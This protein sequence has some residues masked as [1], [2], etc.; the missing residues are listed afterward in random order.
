MNLLTEHF[1]LEELTDSDT[2][3][4][5]GISNRPG[6]HELGNLHMLAKGLERV[7]DALGGVP[8]IIS[9]G[10]RSPALNAFVRGAPSSAHVKGLAADFKAP[11]FGSPRDI[12]LALAPMVEKLQ[13]DQ[14]INEGQ[15]VHVAFVDVTTDKPRGSV[16]TAR[17]DSLGVTYLPG[18]T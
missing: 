7:R 15:W 5:L 4:R 1:S 10:Y 8:I 16:L 12:A 11:A 17:F 18:V 6:Y 9:S 3:L 14:L 2:A 13:I